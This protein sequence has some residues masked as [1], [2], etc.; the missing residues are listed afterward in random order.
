MMK[1]LHGPQDYMYYVHWFGINR[2]MD[3]W[4]FYPNIQKTY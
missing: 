3:D 1:E 4:V 2:R